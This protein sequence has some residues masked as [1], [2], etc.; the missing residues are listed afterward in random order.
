MGVIMNAA[1]RA[2]KRWQE[3]NGIVVKSFKVKHETVKEFI[4]ACEALGVTQSEIITELME[5]YIMGINQSECKICRIRKAL[6]RK[7]VKI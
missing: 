1:T 6:K 3:K 4:K 2:T 5:M 7:G